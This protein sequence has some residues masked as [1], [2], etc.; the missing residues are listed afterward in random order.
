MGGG[1][2]S[3]IVKLNKRWQS[4]LAGLS[5]MAVDTEVLLQYLD[6]LFPQCIGLRVLDSRKAQYYP[7]LLVSFLKK[8]GGELGTMV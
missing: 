1:I 5:I 7:N 6:S 2:G 8:L 4:L 3:V